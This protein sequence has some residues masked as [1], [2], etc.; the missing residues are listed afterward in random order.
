MCDFECDK[1]ALAMNWYKVMEDDLGDFIASQADNDAETFSGTLLTCTALNEATII[2]FRRISLDTMANRSIT[3]NRDLF[4]PDGPD[5][6]CDVTIHGWTDN[7]TRTTQW[8][9]TIFGP[10]MYHPRSMGT[11]LAAFEMKQYFH[12]RPEP[13]EDFETTLTL[14]A[15]KSFS[16]YFAKSWIDCLQCDLTEEQYQQAINFRE[17]G[18]LIAS[19][20]AVDDD[21]FECHNIGE[22]AFKRGLEVLFAHRAMCHVGFKYLEM[23]ASAGILA[24]MPFSDKDVANSQRL[25]QGKCAACAAGKAVLH[26]NDPNK[27]FNSKHGIMTHMSVLPDEGASYPADHNSD[28]ETLGLDFMFIDKQ[29]FLV[30]VGKN[31]G[32]VHVYPTATRTAVAITKILDTIIA[33]YEFK[34]MEVN[35]IV[36]GKFKSNV[37]DKRFRTHIVMGTDSDREA[38]LSERNFGIL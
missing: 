28:L 38:G 24:G 8:G 11:I 33:D 37:Q 25:T 19:A 13:G 9:T 16:M 18:I 29:A 26:S 15:D 7:E 17:R 21:N 35:C 32:Y 3:N 4:G 6:I 14:R 27:N 20:T 30:C 23:T 12:I 36:N 10:M 34:S 2:G 5:Q 1:R 31:S 22:G